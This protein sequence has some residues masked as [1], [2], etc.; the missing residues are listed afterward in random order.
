MKLVGT[1]ERMVN[2]YMREIGS[3]ETNFPALPIAQLDNVLTTF[4]IA[5]RRK[6]LKEYTAESLKTLH[7][8]GLARCCAL[9]AYDKAET[10]TPVD[11]L[12][13]VRFR[14]SVAAYVAKMKEL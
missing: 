2:E 5:A 11:I 6:D 1:A 12:T 8:C 13:D 4:F 14:S 7:H 9:N 3:K 10:C